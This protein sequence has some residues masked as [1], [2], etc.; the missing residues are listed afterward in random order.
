MFNL[1]SKQADC[2]FVNEE[3]WSQFIVSSNVHIKGLT[4][5]QECVRDFRISL[6]Y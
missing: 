4:A 2:Q 5:T 3:N 1:D 6:D